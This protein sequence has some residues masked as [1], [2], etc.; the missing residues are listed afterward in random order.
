MT[1][2]AQ[3]NS[4]QQDN[5]QE[6]FSSTIN[7]TGLGY[8][9]EIRQR[10]ATDSKPV[11]YYVDIS[12]LAGQERDKSKRYQY[13]SLRVSKNL[14]PQIEAAYVNQVLEDGK[15]PQHSLS[16]IVMKIDIYS[17]FFSSWHKDDKY[18]INGEGFLTSFK[19]NSESS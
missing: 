11:A 7:M 2:Q 18:G 16:G 19:A 8:I 14:V 6:Q 3:S 10:P 15:P 1:N 4:N 5:A 9:G 12:L 13:L 17:P